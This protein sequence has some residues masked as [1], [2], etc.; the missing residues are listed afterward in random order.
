MGINRS[1]H[2]Y[3]YIYIDIFVHM[4]RLVVSNTHGSRERADDPGM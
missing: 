1:Q 2:E 4:E 3:M